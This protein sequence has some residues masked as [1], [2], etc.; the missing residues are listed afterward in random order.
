MIDKTKPW[1][2]EF[3]KVRGEDLNVED[4]TGKIIIAGC[5]CCG[6]PFI[7][8]DVDADEVLDLLRQAP[9]AAAEIAR[10]QALN[11]ELVAALQ[12]Q[13]TLSKKG[14]L[15]AGPGEI[16]HVAKL[17]AEALAKAAGGAA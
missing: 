1:V 9:V 2:A 3:G 5:G 17:R 6:S 7:G 10:L 13:D 14:L 8:D 15:Q 16:E 11:T 12:A 4:H